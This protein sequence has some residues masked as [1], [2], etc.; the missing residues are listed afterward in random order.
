MIDGLSRLGALFRIVLPLSAPGL[1]AVAIFTFTG[2]WNELLLALVLITSESQRTA[3]LGLNYL[4]TSD[5]LALG[6]AHGRRGAFLAAADAPLLRGAAL[7]GAGHDRGIG[8]GMSR[9]GQTGRKSRIRKR[10]EMQEQGI[11]VAVGQFNELTDEKLRFA[12]QIGVKRRADEHAE[13]SGRDALGGEGSSGA[14]A[15]DAEEYGLV[16]EAIENVP[17]HFYRQGDARPAGARRADRALPARRSATWA[18]RHPDPRLPLHA[19][20]GLAHGAH[21]AGPRRRRLHEVRHGRGRA[22][23]DGPTASAASS[24]RPTSGVDAIAVLGERRGG[25]RREEQMWDEL[26]LLHQGGA[27]GRRGSRREAG[28]ASGRPAGADARRRRP[29]LP[30]AGRF[31]AR[32]RAQS[33]TARHGDSTS[34]SAAARRCRAARTTCAR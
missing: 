8:E 26:R 27:A 32:V 15:Q 13:A 21:R 17:I 7:H 28:A 1:A 19:E 34:A 3:P 29:H 4:I 14:R 5:V 16:L 6:T 12:A 30:R 24:P 10:N 11:R 2:A 25:R 9:R 20:L 33:R 23:A 31:Q 22:G 18:S